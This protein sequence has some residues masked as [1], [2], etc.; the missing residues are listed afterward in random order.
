MIFFSGG[1]KAWN[2]YTFYDI[3]CPLNIRSSGVCT[4]DDSS[5]HFGIPFYIF[6]L[7]V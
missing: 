4:E 2:L 5:G 7:Y 1:M 6:D 3:K